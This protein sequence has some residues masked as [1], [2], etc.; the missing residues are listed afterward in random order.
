MK[1][2]FSNEAFEVMHIRNFRLFMAYRFLLTS[3]TLMQSVVVGWLLYNITKSVISLGMI[4][5][6]EVIPQIGIALFAGHFVDIWDRKKII[7]Y[8]TFLLLVGSLILA[9]YTLP[10][11]DFHQQLGVWPIYLTIF[12]TGLSR[13]ILMPANTAL[14]GQLVPRRLLTGAATWSST[15]WQVGAVTGPALGGLVYGFFGVLPAL[16]LVFFIYLTCTLL[17]LF[18]KSPGRMVIPEGSTEGIFARMKEGIQYVFNNQILLGAFTLDMF[19][20]LF[21][22][23]VAMLPVFASD[24]LKVG[25]EGLGI[26]RACPAIGAILMGIVLTFY[27]PLKNSGKLLLYSVLGF[28]L[29]MIV[30][31]LSENFYLSAFVLFLSGVFDD[32]SVVIRASILQIFTS[33]EMKGRVAAVNSIFIG[34][35]N[36]LGAFESG[37]AAGL[38]GLVPSVIFGGAMT[39]L[40]VA[41]AAVKS[42]TL[43][44]LKLRIKD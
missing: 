15:T 13:G 32:V 3:A 10:S 17:L 35:S 43:R 20:V 22:G 40:V 38:M 14:L 2:I 27:P 34:S 11:Y 23:A 8:T 39:L 4:G 30:F 18:I 36:E 37:V 21:G 7:F 1:K 19:A 16:A 44:N 41:F 12:L 24:I 42:P 28:G 25:P 9:V 6:T 26:L 5:L 33:D 31:A 29:S